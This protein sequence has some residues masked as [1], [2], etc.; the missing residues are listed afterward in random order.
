MSLPNI[1]YSDKGLKKK[2]LRLRSKMTF[3]CFVIVLYILGQAV[4]IPWIQR[5]RI[6]GNDG[7]NMVLVLLSILGNDRERTSI[8]AL[9]LMPWMTA[10]IIIQLSSLS[11]NREK[12][13]I[14]AGSI[15]KKIRIL[16]CI[17]AIINAFIRSE[18]LEYNLYINDSVVLTK[19]VVICTMTAG[20]FLVLW[21]AEQNSVKGIGG[22]ALIILVNIVRNISQIISGNILGF[23]SGTLS[24]NGDIDK[25]IILL[26]IGFLGIMIMVIFEASEIRLPVQRVM[27][28]SEMATDSYIAIKM[29]P[30]GTQPMMYVMAFYF[31]PYLLFQ[32]LSVVFPD[33]H[34]IQNIAENIDLNR[35]VGL[36]L[37]IGMFVFLTIALA[38]IQINPSDMASQMEEKGDCVVGFYPGKETEYYLKNVVI[39]HSII[40]AA[41]LSIFIGGPMLLRFRWNVDPRMF[42]IPMTLMI[43]TGIMRNIFIEIDAVKKL[44]NYQEVL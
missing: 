10:S 5:Q 2:Y 26:I 23:W 20:S 42:M 15:Q 30:A 36:A 38:Y 22:A 17:F 16:T 13:R 11:L 18:T 32:L 14:S 6:S 44:D 34:V 4:P 27:I 31:L 25:M 12:N 1:E 28:D 8:F 3:S 19:I 29:N 43:M 21:L 39:S 33:N 24:G 35:P 40:S 7:S 9:G 37:Y 41:V